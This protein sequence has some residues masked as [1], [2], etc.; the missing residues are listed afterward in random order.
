MSLPTTT[1]D[2]GINAHVRLV[3]LSLLCDDKLLRTGEAIEKKR[4]FQVSIFIDSF[5]DA[6]LPRFC[7]E[8]DGRIGTQ[9]L[10][11]NFKDKLL[12]ISC[13]LSKQSICFSVEHGDL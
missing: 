11:E 10:D 5:R 12:S 6:F 3:S 9:Q 7:G 8:R 1:A 13:F 2:I 4:K